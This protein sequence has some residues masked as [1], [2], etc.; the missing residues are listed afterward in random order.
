MKPLIEDIKCLETTGIFVQKL[1]YNV[2]GTIL[3]VSADNLAAHSLGGLQESFNVEKFCRFCLA[4]REDIQTRDVRSGNFVLRSPESF[5]EAVNVLKQ[6]DLASVDG[7]KRDC[8]LNS[9]AGF[10]TCTGFPPDFLHDVLEG[11]VPVELSLCLADLISKNYLTLEE[12]NG[13]IQCF[14]FKF[15]DKTNCPQKIPSTFRKTGTVGGNGHENWSLL[16]FLPFLIGHRVPEGDQTWEVILELKDLVELLATPSYTEDSLCYL[17]SKI[18]D[19]RHLL[20]TVFPNY[21]LRPKHHFI[22]HYPCL[23]QRF[24][25]LIEFWTIRFE[26][27]HSFFK[28]VVRDANNF[29][30]IL[31][32]LGSRHQLMLAYYLEMPSIFKPEI[33]TGKVT[34]VCLGVLDGSLVQAV[35]NKFSDVGTVGL[36]PNVYLNGTQYSKGMILSVGSTSGLPDFGRILEICIVL[37]GRVCFF[38]EPFVTYYVEHLRSYHLV[39]KSPAEC[40]L[41]NP[42]DLNDY[43]PLVSYLVQDRLCVT[44]R[45][46]LLK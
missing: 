3:F 18:S 21:K 27:K 40:L 28:K 10:H 44:P 38:I 29:K 25:P 31:L 41:V 12:L 17:Q 8:P 24:G 22:E 34:D 43:M 14:P 2:K 13:E 30:N 4:S 15:S 23:I 19:H 36:T 37:A 45:T 32:T 20:L 7:V 11:I 42:E 35:L 1:G 26:A 9:L 39:K 16:R 33:E 46:F 5:D 6:S